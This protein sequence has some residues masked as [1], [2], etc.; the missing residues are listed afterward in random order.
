MAVTVRNLTGV[1]STNVSLSTDLSVRLK[2]D[3]LSGK[4]KK[5]QK[6]TEQVICEEYQVS[7]TPVREA[8]VALESEGLIET[9]PNRGAF[10][11]GLSDKD[12]DDIFTLR[13]IYEVQATRWAIERITDEEMEALEENFDFMEF[14]TMKKDVDKMLNINVNFHQMI[15]KASH[16]R[17]LRH[18]LSSYQI[19]VKH[20]KT[21]AMKKD[22]Y[23][24]SVLEEHRRIF[25]AFKDGDVEAGAAAMEEHMIN[26]R[27]RHK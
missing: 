8:L 3:I 26:S 12:M 25:R 10:V 22:D 20:A 4:L 11:I 14:Y 18:L 16:N 17:L 19:Y 6:L 23:L 7:R 27:K 13:R 2:E 1:K 15:Y 24:E 9:I 21:A 5:N